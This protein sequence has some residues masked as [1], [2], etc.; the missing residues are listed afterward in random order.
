MKVDPKS[1]LLSI[2]V[3]VVLRVPTV[4]RFFLGL[5]VVDVGKSSLLSI[6][7]FSL[8][9][10]VGREVINVGVS[11]PMSTIG[12]A[13]ADG[14][15]DKKTSSSGWTRFVLGKS[16]SLWKGSRSIHGSRFIGM[17]VPL[18]HLKRSL[19]ENSGGKNA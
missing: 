12:L 8:V 19:P 5:K 2:A 15:N 7:V 16:A 18:P 13:V 9:S 4:V 10:V 14:P 11:V 6:V 1:N 3:A 17:R